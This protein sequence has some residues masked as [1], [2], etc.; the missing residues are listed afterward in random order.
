[1]DPI[2]GPSCF[3]LGHV[4][5]LKGA[6]LIPMLE[7]ALKQALILSDGSLRIFVTRSIS[8][9]F[10]VITALTVAI[11]IFKMIKRARIRG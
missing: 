6:G 7:N 8:L 10:L 9:G 1:M 4:E 3:S 5:R 2:S 11:I